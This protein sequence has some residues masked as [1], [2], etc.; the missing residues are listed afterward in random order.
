MATA[1]DQRIEFLGALGAPLAARLE[2]PRG[3]PRAYALFAHCFTCSKETIAATRIAREL[4]A[5]GIAT[6][7]FD[8]TG[9]GSSGGDFANTNFSSNVGDLIAAADWLRQT[10]AAPTILIGH[11]LGGAAVLAAAGEIEEVTAVAT[12]GAPADPGHVEHLFQGSAAEIEEAGEAE[13]T[14]AGR[15]FR[16]RKQFLED[17]RGQRLEERIGKLR[18]ALL[19]LHAPFDKIVGI[20]NAAEIFTAAKHPKSFV[21]LDRADH[22]LSNRAHAA[23]AAE[24]IAAWASQYLPEAEGGQAGETQEHDQNAVIVTERSPKGFTQDITAGRH[25]LV[26]DEP[27][28]VGGA[29][30][31]PTPYTFLLAALG[32]CTAMTLRMYARRKALPL[33]GVAVRLTHARTHAADCEGCETQA[34][35]VDVIERAVTLSGALSADQRQRL[36]EIADKCPVHRTL[37]SETVIRTR[38]AA[39]DL[40]G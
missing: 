2:Q 30:A 38:E 40:A 39:A 13:V 3:Q 28:S 14:L 25:Q 32:T 18:R 34:G 7:R 22:L 20:H 12:I 23:Y 26:G 36:L 21:S 17:I 33:D 11:S 6:L 5:R 8:F 37:T 9:L 10:H 24:V 27:G 35:Q 4:A 1:G 15:K 16:V 29:D 31:G 19:V